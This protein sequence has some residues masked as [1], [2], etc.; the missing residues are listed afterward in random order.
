MNTQSS[1]AVDNRPDP[2]GDW[3]GTAIDTGIAFQI[4]DARPRVAAASL[5]PGNSVA[6]S[7]PDGQTNFVW[8]FHLRLYKRAATVQVG[9]LSGRSLLTV[10]Y[11]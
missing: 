2:C 1:L 9:A 7:L 5:A 3:A 10:T 11:P 4:F 8:P 6:V